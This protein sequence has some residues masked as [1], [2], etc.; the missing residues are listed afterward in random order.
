[1]NRN[2][3]RGG[4]VRIAGRLGS[5]EF[6]CEITASKRADIKQQMRD[7][8]EM[9]EKQVPNHLDILWEIEEDFI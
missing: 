2:S 9:I 5:R 3:E 6:K 8:R 7:Y 1:M 4:T